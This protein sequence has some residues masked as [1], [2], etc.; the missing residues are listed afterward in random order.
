MKL[1]IKF[2]SLL[3]LFCFINSGFTKEVPET[4]EAQLVADTSYLDS[5]GIIK[6]GVLY[7][8]APGWHIYWKNS[9][10]SG[11]PT[12]VDFKLPEGFETG[13]LYWP[14]PSIFTRD[15]N[16]T[17]YG[18]ENSVLLWIDARV[19]DEFTNNYEIPI[20][21]KTSWVSCEEI[22]IPGN[23]ELKTELNLKDENTNTDLFKKWKAQLPEEDKRIDSTV[24]KV[25]LDDN[26]RQYDIILNF[27]EPIQH[28]EF[29]PIPEKSLKIEDI[30]YLNKDAKTKEISFKISLYK[31]R[32][33][34]SDVLNTVVAYED[35]SKVRKGINFPI[36]ISGLSDKNKH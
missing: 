32:N 36:N 6:L 10:D 2:T 29:F 34:K 21:V 20:T 1:I 11:L 23:A 33:L 12:K 24:S 28:V 25:V 4:V 17:D 19:P 30:S 14:L 26:K 35:S 22:C 15:G 13:E 3:I 31:G 8:L 18:Y 16:I 9:G 7:K 27:D 5:E